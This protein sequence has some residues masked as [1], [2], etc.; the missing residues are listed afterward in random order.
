MA[1]GRE[2]TSKRVKI[3]TQLQVRIPAELYNRY[4]FGNEAECVATPTGVEFR[5]LKSAA[6]QSTDLLQQLVAEGY[7]GDDL[8]EE[9]RLRVADEIDGPQYEDEAAEYEE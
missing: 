7:S 1:G 8:I 2:F 6:E 5:P 4:G 3:S 9:F